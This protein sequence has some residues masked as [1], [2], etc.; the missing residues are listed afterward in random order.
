MKIYE[1][2]ENIGV[3]LEIICKGKNLCL[4]TN[5][6]KAKENQLLLYPLKKD[7]KVVNLTIGDLDIS[8]K[9]NRENDKPLY[10]KHCKVEMVAY[11]KNIYIGVSHEKD[12]TELNRRGDFRLSIGEDG[13]CKVVGNRNI[14]D[15]IL[16]NVSNS[17]F[18]IVMK[19]DEDFK[20]GETIEIAFRDE[21]LNFVLR[22]V[23]NIVRIEEIE[24]SFKVILGCKL[25]NANNNMAKYIN[26]KQQS[27][28]SKRNGNKAS[29]FGRR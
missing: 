26:N 27:I 19:K 28:L 12:G 10:W 29:S 13:K 11:K 7:G 5:V 24:E 9:L 3:E 8:L 1:L 4:K 22:V 6:F 16:K 20:V 17:G 21:D 15:M 23:G 14:R 2:E 25:Q 18:A